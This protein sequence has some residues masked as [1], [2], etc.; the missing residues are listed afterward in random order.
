MSEYQ[1]SKIE[2]LLVKKPCLCLKKPC[3]WLMHQKWW[4]VVIYTFAPVLS[5][6][7]TVSVDD[8]KFGLVAPGYPLPEPR[9]RRVPPGGLSTRLQKILKNIHKL[10]CAESVSG[11]HCLYTHQMLPMTMGLLSK[12]ITMQCPWQPG[13]QLSPGMAVATEGVEADYDLRLCTSGAVFSCMYGHTCTHMQC[14]HPCV[15]CGYAFY[16]F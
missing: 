12:A 1:A 4:L 14:G 6:T 11:P 9:P 16:N 13:R 3:L 5:H 8:D 7:H 10:H 15:F 2:F